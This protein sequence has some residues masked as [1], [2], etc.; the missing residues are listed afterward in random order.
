MVL[1][2]LHI[3]CT[4]NRIKNSRRFAINPFTK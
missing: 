2:K 4:K 3:H 1:K